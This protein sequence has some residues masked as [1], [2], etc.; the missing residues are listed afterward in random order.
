MN[1]KSVNKLHVNLTSN[2]QGKFAVHLVSN[3]CNVSQAQN[4]YFSPMC[5]YFAVN[6]GLSKHKV[7]M[8][9]LLSNMK[10]QTLLLLQHRRKME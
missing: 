3:K 8:Q 5:T 6:P 4:K 9:T 10:G 7:Y 2:F 1:C